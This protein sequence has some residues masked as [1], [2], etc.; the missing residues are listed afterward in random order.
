MVEPMIGRRMARHSRHG[1][2]LAV[3]A[4][5]LAACGGSSDN[6]GSTAPTT[7][8]AASTDAVAEVD[9]TT[10]DD[11]PDSEADENSD[12]GSSADPGGA[13]DGAL[14]SLLS[15]ELGLFAIERD[16]GE[17]HEATIDGVGLPVATGWLAWTRSDGA[18]SPV[19]W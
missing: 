18:V 4:L 16:T 12:E 14:V 9:D 1:V 7:D 17:F 3:T 5:M 15:F 8:Q 19:R 10:V 11:E 13:V 6:S 2:I